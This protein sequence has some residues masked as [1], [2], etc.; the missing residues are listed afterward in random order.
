MDNYV[1][2]SNGNHATHNSYTQ[3]ASEMG[4]PAAIIYILFL[5]TALK[6]LKK[7]QE[8]TVSS[9]KEQRWYYVAVGL[10][11]ALGGYMVSSFFASVS[12]LWYVYYLV[13]Y[14]I[15]LDHFLPSSDPVSNADPVSN[16]AA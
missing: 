9:R 11:A 5:I 2:R 8:R 1:L 14:A 4:I 16:K 15:A 6:R 10:Q 12:Y 7:T 3:V 13:G